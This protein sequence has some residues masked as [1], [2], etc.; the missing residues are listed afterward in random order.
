M[1]PNHAIVIKL[2]LELKTEGEAGERVKNNN[3]V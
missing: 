1:E 3:S 2:L